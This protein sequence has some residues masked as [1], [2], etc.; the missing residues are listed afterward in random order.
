VKPLW[1]LKLSREGLYRASQTP[2]EFV[3][4]HSKYPATGDPNTSGPKTRPKDLAP[5][6]RPME[7]IVEPNI[8]LQRYCSHINPAV[9]NF[10]P[11]RG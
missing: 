6:T 2:W 10:E 8:C 9:C 4:T 5:L 11:A 3:I 7:V 1:E